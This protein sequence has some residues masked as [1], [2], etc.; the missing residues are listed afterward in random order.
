MLYFINDS[1]G[2]IKSENELSVGIISRGGLIDLDGN[3]YFHGL[4]KEEDNTEI[5]HLCSFTSDGIERWTF[6][7]EDNF[8]LYS[9]ISI[10][11]DGSTLYT[12]GAAKHIYAIRTNDG[13]VLW[14]RSSADICAAPIV[15]SDGNIYT[16]Y[17]YSGEY[18]IVCFDPA[19]EERWKYNF[20]TELSKSNHSMSEYEGEMCLNLNGYIYSYQGKRLFSCDY[21]GQKRWLMELPSGSNQGETPVTCDKDS[22]IYL[23]AGQ[24]L[25]AYNQEGEML[26]ECNFTDSYAY[27][28]SLACDGVAYLLDMAH[29]LIAIE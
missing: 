1:D 7:C 22:T 21:I 23:T 2:S 4:T 6:S 10:S 17:Q 29:T 19:G 27:A 9:Y 28:G 3:L 16:Y 13:S 12:Q 11:P 25:Y 24:Y 14:R 26:F 20:F 8:N 18:G 15:D 5:Y